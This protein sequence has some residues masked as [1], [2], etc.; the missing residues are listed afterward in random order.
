MRD[1]KA[2]SSLQ[3]QDYVNRSLLSTC[4]SLSQ[5]ERFQVW[6]DLEGTAAAM[7][8]VVHKVCSVTSDSYLRSPDKFPPSSPD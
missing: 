4:P 1:C 6:G 3:Q 2:V 8:H 7:Q 5:Y